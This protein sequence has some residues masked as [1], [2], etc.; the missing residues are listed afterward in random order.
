MVTA[1]PERACAASEPKTICTPLHFAAAQ[2]G[3]K[4]AENAEI[5]CAVQPRGVLFPPL[6]VL[7]DRAETPA[8]FLIP[9]AA[10]PA[11]LRQSSESG[12]LTAPPPPH[13]RGSLPP[14]AG[15]PDP[16]GCGS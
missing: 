6:R 3:D 12:V 2:R 14:L 8:R 10:S 13:S 1:A 5:D 7:A 4:A 15:G 11:L 16:S 9:A